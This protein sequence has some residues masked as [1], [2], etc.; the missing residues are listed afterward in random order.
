MPPLAN[1]P[2]PDE[3]ESAASLM[4]LTRGNSEDGI[5]FWAYMY[6][7]TSMAESFKQARDRGDICIGDYG[8]IIEW[9]EGE[10]PPE[11][12]RTRMERDFGMRHD[13]EDRLLKAIAMLKGTRG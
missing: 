12:I 10:N 6:I 11:D 4:L 13:Y 5:P 3:M 2:P 7:R 8:T 9:G 1:F